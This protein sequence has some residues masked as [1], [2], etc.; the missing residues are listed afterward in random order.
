MLWLIVLLF[1]GQFEVA[2]RAGLVALNNN[3]L[4]VAESK[5]ESASKL[6]PGDARVWLAL[7]QTYWKLHKL[8]ASETAA[9]KAEALAAEPSI[10]EGLALY[11]SEA[12]N[13]G[14]AAELEARYA[15]TAPDALPRAA[16]LYLRAGEPKLA[17]QLTR[18]ALQAND[19][20]ALRD[21][22]GKAYEANGDPA[23]AIMEFQAA[24]RQSRY[25]ETFYFDLAQVQLKQQ[26]F[27]AALGTLDSGR[28][29]FDKSAQLE[30]AS[31]VAYYGL[32]R[33]PEAIDAFLRTIRL[34]PAVEQPYVFLGRM[35]DQAED[36]LPAITEVFAA[37]S[38]TAPDNYLSSFLYGK[39][40]ALVDPDHAAALLRQSIA[41]NS[42]F[43]ESHF[44][45]GVLLEAQ[46]KL[47]DAATEIKR[48]IELNA[49]DPT[50]HYRLARIYDRLGKAAEAG[51]ER[52]LHAKLS[53]AGAVIK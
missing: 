44:E 8:P 52:E 46:S 12:A 7:A 14:K 47:D 24:I 9:K 35:L 50:P 11:Y 41:R 15:E 27:A 1:A 10:L 21:M 33:F 5:L 43:W 4:A 32:R 20:A 2:F 29:Y 36:K 25:D 19:R 17:I 40:L 45:L 23:R 22:L 49:K 37:F 42:Q 53:A 39:S 18:K 28:K 48:C 30:L 34:D 6:Q 38:K 31:G 13:Y 26:A 16:D 51:A 3:D